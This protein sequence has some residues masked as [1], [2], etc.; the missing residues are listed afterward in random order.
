MGLFLGM[1]TYGRPFYA[2]WGLT[3][4]RGAVFEADRRKRTLSLDELVAGAL[5][6]YPIYYDW[7]LKGYTTCEATLNTLLKERERLSA[8][9]ELGRLRVGFVRRQWRKVNILAKAFWSEY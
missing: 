4:D 3:Q 1:V 7:E 6:H 2:G 5:L 8:S 9:G